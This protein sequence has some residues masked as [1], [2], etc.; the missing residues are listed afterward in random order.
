MSNY[1]PPIIDSVFN[2]NNFP[3]KVELNEEIHINNFCLYG[4]A[5]GAFQAINTTSTTDYYICPKSNTL[6]PISVLSNNSA[7][8]YYNNALNNINIKYVGSSTAKLAMH[9]ITFNFSFSHQQ[10]SFKIAVFKNPTFNDTTKVISTSFL[11]QSLIAKYNYSASVNDSATLSFMDTPL[12]N[13]VYYIGINASNVSASH[14]VS[15]SG[16]TWNVSI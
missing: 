6:L 4:V 14:Y 16:V 11:G 9:T 15:I 5:T 12:T 7:L 3:D 13:D 8:F 1:P 10:T 2:I